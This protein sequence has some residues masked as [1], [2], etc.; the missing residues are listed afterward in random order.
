MISTTSAPPQPR[1]R[2]LPPGG[3]G[4]PGIQADAEPE[5]VHPG[6]EPAQYDATPLP[7]TLERLL[8]N[9]FGQGWTPALGA[10]M[11]SAGGARTWFDTQ[12]ASGPDRFFETS[13]GW[14]PSL[15]LSAAEIWRR[16]RDEVQ[17]FWEAGFDHQRWCLARRIHSERPL[18]ETMTDF[19]ENLLHVPAA[20]EAEAFFRAA[21]GTGIRK[22]ALGSFAELLRF[23][24]THPAMGCYLNLATSRKSAP[25]ED[26][27]RELLEVHT[28]G[29]G[30]FTE[31][32]VVDSARI[33]TGYRVDVWG[34]WAAAYDPG[35][36]W[37][38]AVQVLDFRHDNRAEDGR[39]VARAYLDHLAR[40]PLTAERIARRLAVRFV[41]DD[42]SPALVGLLS[43]TY[44][45]HD[46]A[47]APVLRALV[48]SAEFRRAAGR[49][50]RLPE[51]D[52]VATYRV[53][54]AGL[55]KPVDTDSAAH[56][57]IWQCEALGLAPFRWPRPDGRPDAA[58]SWTSTARVLQA[59]QM[60]LTMAGGWWPTKE[61]DLRPAAS[62]LPEPTLRFDLLV[63]HLARSILGSAST[64]TLLKSA[65]E[66]V[67][68]E[69]DTTITSTH[70]VVRWGMPTLLSVFLD[71]PAHLT[72]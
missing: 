20:G 46:T 72:R 8:G 48:D 50:V 61:I 52:L 34:T 14:W 41:A 2:R 47:I 43:R 5:P 70:R 45:A 11:A 17:P 12:L 37:T 68:V 56:V 38:G 71:H 21:Y 27:A 57:S 67:Q 62:W 29:A 63:D 59:F 25:N 51:E 60:H 31:K 32:D 58:A 69:P 18:L 1:R 22:R 3:A 66:A 55:R 54:G 16:D 42:P 15:T 65:C 6:F 40:H 39:S 30:N 44:R 28:V 19:W 26:L 64:S 49:K 53:L 7:S 33:L 36:H 13:R 23:S 35:S 4:R 9:R 24:T 10:A